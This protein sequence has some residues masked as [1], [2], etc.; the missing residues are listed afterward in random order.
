MCDAAFDESAFVSPCVMQRGKKMD[1][2]LREARSR[3]EGEKSE[4]KSVSFR[5]N[6]PSYAASIEYERLHKI[7]KRGERE[8]ER[9]KMH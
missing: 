1:L 2:G 6:V 9:E 3:G 8:R 5:M 7:E 4:K